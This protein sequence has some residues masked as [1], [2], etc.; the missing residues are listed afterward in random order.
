MKS[1]FHKQKNVCGS[2]FRYLVLILLVLFLCGCA[3][4]PEPAES[5]VS[6]MEIALASEPVTEAAAS[7]EAVTSTEDAEMT[8]AEHQE[9]ELADDQVMVLLAEAQ[10]LEGFTAK[11][12][13]ESVGLEFGFWD[14]EGTVYN[15]SGMELQPDCLAFLC[16]DSD[17]LLTDTPLL[18][19]PEDYI[20]GGIDPG[21][22]PSGRYYWYNL[23]T[24]M[25]CAYWELVF[26][27]RGSAGTLYSAA[28][29]VK[30]TTDL[31]EIGAANDPFTLL[32]S[33]SKEL[34]GFTAELPADSVHCEF[35]LWDISGTVY[36]NSG[37]TLQ[38]DCMAFCGYDSDGLLTDTP[39]L[40][41]PE[42]YIWGGMDPGRIPNG[43]S[44][45]YTFSSDAVC[46][47][48][49][50]VFFA[51]DG[52]GNFYVTTCTVKPET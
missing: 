8:E 12:S 35:G 28:C 50:F 16:Y 47:Y 30:S 36:N 20:R 18:L 7:T 11:P 33:V 29:T 45:E 52:D 10:E 3:S 21:Q 25:A 1:T 15:N 32:L 2:V 22:I 34:E 37:I 39:F 48:W 43:R 26:F 4:R 24:N 6:M 38:P 23:C 13:A 17:G 46:A 44:Y 9:A 40:L 51:R 14:M 19:R 49:E 41:R 5:R 27:A 31:R 42:E